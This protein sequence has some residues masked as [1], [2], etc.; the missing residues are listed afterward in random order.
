MLAYPRGTTLYSEDGPD[1]RYVQRDSSGVAGYFLFTRGVFVD[2]GWVFTNGE[3]EYNNKVCAPDDPR[4][5]ALIA[6]VA[7]V[8]AL[9]SAVAKEAER[10]VAD[11][12]RRRA[13]LELIR[14]VLLAKYREPPR[15]S[16]E[17]AAR[18]LTL[19]SGL[20]VI[21]TSAVVAVGD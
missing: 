6:R 13:A 21:V 4:L 18:L 7:P 11:L 2:Q 3:C 16:S 12:N 15:V 10:A 17:L 19:P 14:T 8:E 9:A 1:G 20:L 5:L